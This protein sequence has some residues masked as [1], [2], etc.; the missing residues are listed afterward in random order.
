VD[1]LEQYSVA[2]RAIDEAL[3][4]SPARLEDRFDLTQDL[5]EQVGDTSRRQDRRFAP[6][7]PEASAFVISGMRS[8]HALA[9]IDS[10]SDRRGLRPRAMFASLSA[11]AK[12]AGSRSL[13]V[14]GLL[15][16]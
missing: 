9:R 14:G 2:V 16:F 5:F 13:G 6:F 1:Y 15:H 12:V 4:S 11:W 8:D 10:S 3:A 7:K